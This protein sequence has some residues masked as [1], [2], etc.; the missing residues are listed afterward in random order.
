MMDTKE[1]THK[2]QP[3]QE[4]QSRPDKFDLQPGDLKFFN[5]NEE[6]EKYVKEQ[7]PDRHFVD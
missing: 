1:S 7:F 6:L 4:Q 2:N 3:P 5:T